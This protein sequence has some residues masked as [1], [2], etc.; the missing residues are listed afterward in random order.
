MSFKSGLSGAA[1]GATI[2]SAVPVF[3]TGLG[4][5]VGG[6]AGLFG[7][8]PSDEELAAQ[9][10]QRQAIEAIKSIEIPDLDKALLIQQ[11]Q[12]NGTLSPE[13]IQNLNLNADQKQLLTEK[14]ETL[15]RQQY[16]MNALKQ[17]SQTGMSAQ[18]LA[19]MQEARSA[20]A[21]DTSAKTNQLLQQAQ[22]RGQLGAG[23][24]LASQLMSAQQ[25]GQRASKEA[26]Q[27]AA[28]AGQARQQALSQYGNMA[29]Q[30]RGQ[31]YTTQQANMQNELARQRFLDENSLGRQQA[32]V[33]AKNQANMYNLQRQQGVGDMNVGGSIQELQRQREA[34][35]QESQLEL[36]KGELLSKAYTGQAEAAQKAA[37][38]AS[39]SDT[40]MMSGLGSLAGDLG[41]AGVFGKNEAGYGAFGVLGGSTKQGTPAQATSSGNPYFNPAKFAGQKKAHGG[42]IDG[43]EIVGHDSEENDII[44]IM[45]S[46]G[47]FVIPKTKMKDAESAKAFIDKHFKVKK[48]PSKHEHLLDLI[49]ELHGSKKSKE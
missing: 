18:D 44:P 48:E 28:A 26:L 9:E 33:A 34:Q 25:G 47:E 3:G 24:T 15:A 7:G 43:P 14:P 5:I 46:A 21:E 31:D 41:K 37:A 6:I 36:K 35:A 39:T 23:D 4:A 12:Q 19:Q 11:Y 45:A 10:A 49:A 20:V 17:M 38:A 8:G 13:L 30:V 16:A 42:E 29:G 32:N 2:G 1:T 27:T 22:M 40:A